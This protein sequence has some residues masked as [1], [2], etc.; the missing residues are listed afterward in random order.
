MKKK[1]GIIE[2]LRAATSEKEIAKLTKRLGGYD[3][4]SPKTLRKFIKIS[5]AKR[6]KLRKPK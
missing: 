2:T 5:R 1:K 3:Y 6:A 4:A